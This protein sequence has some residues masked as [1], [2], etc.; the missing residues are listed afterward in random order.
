MSDS[1][2]FRRIRVGQNI[3]R[4][5]LWEATGYFKPLMTEYE[6]NFPRA[7][8]RSIV[9]MEAHVVLEGETE[10]PSYFGADFMGK[11]EPRR[12]I[13][14]RGSSTAIA[15]VSYLFPG[16]IKM[17]DMKFCEIPFSIR[18]LDHDRLERFE[19]ECRSHFTSY[20]YVEWNR[21]DDIDLKN[22]T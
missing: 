13:L 11:V 10:A 15:H 12:S 18:D 7:H 22:I 14:D 1:R 8:P 4:G 17:L 6:S 21:V 2:I 5:S 20:W 3:P 16:E 9:F 19:E